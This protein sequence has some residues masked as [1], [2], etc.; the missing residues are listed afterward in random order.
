MPS[1]SH[2]ARYAASAC[3]S[4]SGESSSSSARRAARSKCTISASSSARSS[5]PGAGSST[6]S[7]TVTFDQGSLV[8]G[9]GTASGVHQRANGAARSPARIWRRVSTLLALALLAAP[10]GAEVDRFTGETSVETEPL[11]LDPF[12]PEH[13]GF[14]VTLSAR[15]KK[16]GPTPPIYLAIVLESHYDPGPRAYAVGYL[17]GG[18]KLEIT[19]VRSTTSCEGSPCLR[20]EVFA[21]TMPE[22][23][24]RAGGPVEVSLRGPGPRRDFTLPAA[25]VADFLERVDAQGKP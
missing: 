15:G 21:V 2:S 22:D 23:A 24:L 17:L 12:R 16:E 9:T 4:S 18:R 5:A 11:M 25:F 13:G 20:Q 7:P 6:H 19:P 10:A 14:V 1:R 8:A 3:A